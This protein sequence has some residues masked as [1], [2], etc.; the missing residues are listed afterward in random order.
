MIASSLKAPLKSIYR[1]NALDA[2]QL[3]L[4]LVR[5]LSQEAQSQIFKYFPLQ[6]TFDLE[7]ALKFIVFVFSEGRNRASPGNALQNVKYRELSRLKRVG[8]GIFAV[9]VPWIWSK[10]AKKIANSSYGG[11]P[12]ESAEYKLYRLSRWIEISVRALS[13]VN[14]VVFLGGGNF[15]SLVDRLLGMKLEYIEPRINRQVVFDLINQQLVWHGFSEF[16]LFFIPLINL[17][18]VRRWLKK[19]IR[20]GF[21]WTTESAQYHTE[22]NCPICGEKP[23]ISVL[24]DCQ[25]RFCDYCLR[26]TLLAE[27]NYRCPLCE[28]LI[29]SCTRG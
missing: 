5:L 15:R 7:T 16:L 22:E 27:T 20:K 23:L 18:K 11:F 8:F 28:N 2:L 29:R 6:N 21:G 1:V 13:L 4:E 19:W 9:F 17:H 12:R 24:S 26:G 3:D 14:F 10:W 25:H